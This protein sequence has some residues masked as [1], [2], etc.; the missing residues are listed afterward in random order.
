[1][2]GGL[3]KEAAT[4]SPTPSSAPVTTA[5]ATPV[6]TASGSPAPAFAAVGAASTKL[7]EVTIAAKTAPVHVSFLGDQAG[8]TPGNYTR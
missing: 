4:A 7:S 5:P 8:L 2:G 3:V 6:A 1:V